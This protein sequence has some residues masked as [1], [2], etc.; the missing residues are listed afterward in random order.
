MRTFSD[1]PTLVAR[2]C[3]SGR[4]A[5]SVLRRGVDRKTGRG[6]V[7]EELVCCDPENRRELDLGL[8]GFGQ[9]GAVSDVPENEDL[10]WLARVETVWEPAGC[11]EVAAG[12]DARRYSSPVA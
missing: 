10:R 5:R 4:R 9:E 7:G 3:R 1:R 2:R 8:L 11:A 6:Q 12:N